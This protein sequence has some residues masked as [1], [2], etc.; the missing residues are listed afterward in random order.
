MPTGFEPIFFAK[1]K[2]EKVPKGPK[3][4][5]HEIRGSLLGLNDPQVLAQFEAFMNPGQIVPH[6]T[7]ATLVGTPNTIG[8]QH[9][10]EIPSPIA[11]LTPL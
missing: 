11:S 9:S 8:Q 1:H 7:L 5:F 3:V 4:L 2:V 6:S 10:T